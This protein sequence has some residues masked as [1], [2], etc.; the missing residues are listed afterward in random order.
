MI[1]KFLDAMSCYGRYKG[2]EALKRTLDSSKRPQLAEAQ[3][4]PSELRGILSNANATESAPIHLFYGFF[5]R[6]ELPCSNGRT[7]TSGENLTP[8]QSTN[9][10]IFPASTDAG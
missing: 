6:F 5:P 7:L 10:K 1:S 4:S 2:T 9:S 3:R 8:S